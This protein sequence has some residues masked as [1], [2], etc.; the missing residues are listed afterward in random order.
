M[1]LGLPFAIAAAIVIGLVVM[2]LRDDP[3]VVMPE[4]VVAPA[5][6]PAPEV[7][8]SV[9][10]RPAPLAAETADA[11]PDSGLLDDLDLMMLLRE[12]GFGR[13]E[14]EWREWAASRGYPA[15]DQAGTQFYDQPYEQ[16]DD[17]TLR[18]LANNGDMWASQILAKRIAKTD[19]AGAI[20]LYRQAAMRGSIYAMSELAGLYSKIADSRR[21]VEFKAEPGALEQIYAM[22]DAPVSPEVSG[23]A[24]T[25]VADMAGTEPMFGNIAASQLSRRLND[26]QLEEACTIARGM[27][28][29]LRAQRETQ[30][31]GDF[32]RTPPPLVY[33]D[34]SNSASCAE[35]NEGPNLDLTGC[36]QVEVSE[37]GQTNQI[38]LCADPPS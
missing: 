12:Y 33:W 5:A 17:E 27:Y 22:R 8:A 37:E 13:L 6:E 14:G 3:D 29:E 10:K 7:T 19:P 35:E 31:L 24:W 36:R 16:Y 21:E 2:A 26:E 28:D 25:M 30:G 23:Y 1:K 32:N 15:F 9:P 20:E 18:G 38:W 4:P 34:P 11:P